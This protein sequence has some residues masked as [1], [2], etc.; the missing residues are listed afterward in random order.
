MNI[1]TNQLV[2]NSIF[3]TGYAL[4]VLVFILLLLATSRQR[5]AIAEMKLIY[6]DN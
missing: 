6:K 4:P 2:A 3:N 5:K 1:L